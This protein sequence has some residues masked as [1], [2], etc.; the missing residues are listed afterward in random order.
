MSQRVP[1]KFPVLKMPFDLS[2]GVDQEVYKILGDLKSGV[3]VKNF[4]CSAVLYYARSPLVLSAN[5]LIQSLEE[6]NF[7]HYF[8]HLIVKVDSLSDKLDGLSVITTCADVSDSV[9]YEAPSGVS[10]TDKAVLSSLR[11]KFK[12]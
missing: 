12:L 2:L 1:N 10:D 9:S 4:L 11:D 8:D 5:A 6:R 7:N 3:E